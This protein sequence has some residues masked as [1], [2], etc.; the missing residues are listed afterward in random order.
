MKNVLTLIAAAVLFASCGGDTENKTDKLRADLKAKQEEM[1][2]LR[3]EIA[4]LEVEIANGAGGT[5]ASGKPVRIKTVAYGTFEHSIDIQGRVDAEESVSVGPQMP[6]LVKRVYVR[7]GDKVSAGQVLAE[8]DA[9]AMSQQISALKVQRDL[10]KQVYDRQKNLWDQKIGTEVQYLQSKTQYEALESQVAAMQE[11]ME[12]SRI[13]APMAGVVDDVNIK[14]GEMASPGFSNI[15]VVSTSKLRVK[16]E[17]AEAYVAQVKTGSPVNVYLPDA[18]K[19]IPSKI[20]YASRM[21]SN[22]NRTFSVE[23]AM[24]PN[25][26]NVVPNMI[27]IMKI[28]DYKNDSAIVVP[29][30]VI[31]QN[32]N[33]TNYVYVAVQ[34]DKNLVAEKRDITYTRTYGGQAEIE[35]GLQPGD[36]LITEGWNDL[37]PGD[38]ISPLK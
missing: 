8:L 20:T 28:N 18:N 11:Q 25:E 35:S 13:K 19:T 34:K 21:I 26:E 6:G 23:V 22:M 38:V 27:A 7:S 15:V 16:G 12:M 30:A 3:K 9:D 31:Q 36:Q 14:A 37:N 29:L 4:Q 10:A 17:V 32:A 33:G 1:E 5:T 2:K 24:N